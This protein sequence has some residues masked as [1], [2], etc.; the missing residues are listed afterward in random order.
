MALR[1]IT[2]RGRAKIT[3]AEAT[4]DLAAI[5]AATVNASNDVTIPG[6]EVGDPVSVNWTN[7]AA[8][9]S[10]SGYVSATNVVTVVAVNS[11]AGSINADSA[12]FYLA[13]HHRD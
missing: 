10:I 4:I 8:A 11:T 9:I 2:R 7:E 3:F 5:N 13:V 1:T 6:A 12:T